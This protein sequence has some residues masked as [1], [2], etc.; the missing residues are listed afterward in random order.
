M[1]LLCILGAMNALSRSG[2]RAARA[3]L[4]ALLDEIEARGFTAETVGAAA[5]AISL[6]RGLEDP[7]LLARAL[8][9]G[10]EANRS[11][12]N[13]RLAVICGEEA[14]GLYTKRGDRL[15]EYKAR[16]LVGVALWHG[17]HLTEAFVAFEE[18]AALAKI[19]GDVERHVRSLNMIGVVLGQL[20][21]YPAAATALDQALA[22]CAAGRYEFDRVLVVNNKAQML[23]N[24]AREST[25]PAESVRHAEAALSLLSEGMAEKV[26][27]AWPAGGLLARDTLGQA[28]GLTGAPDQ[29]LAMFE[30]N[31]RLAQLKSDETAMALAGMGIA[32]ALLDLGRPDR[33]LSYCDALRGSEG[34]RLWPALLPRIENA[35]AK[36]LHALGRDAEAYAAFGRYHDRMMQNNI[37]VAFQYTKYMEL[38]VQLESSRAETATY[39]K[40]A[41]ELTL[42]KQAAEEASR[43]KSEFLANMSHELR[44]PL[45]SI[46]GFADL[47][48]SEIFGSILPKY[49]E[50]LQDIFASGQRL[51]SL[52]D[53]LLDLAQAESG[54][55]ELAEE[56]VPINVLLDDATTRLADAAASKDVT[57]QWSLRAGA[58][59]R[60]DR[61]RLA[62]CILN[63]LSNAID[64]VPSGGIVELATR[65][66]AGGLAVA[67]SALGVGLRPEDVPKAFERY[68]Q[69]GDAKAVSSTG[70]GLPLAKRLIELHGGTAAL[71]SGAEFGTTV[72]L[73][74]PAERLPARS[75]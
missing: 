41:H 42:A 18:A 14:A 22:L 13:W 3:R 2:T 20:R 35:A 56:F 29:A 67:I 55:L 47:I 73:R 45:N 6:A 75:A 69:G 43:A 65:F 60:G 4:P 31:E 37:R 49:R 25:D 63:V 5:E 54:A 72:T 70:F 11:A 51:L 17:A 16:Y 15:G 34:A 44:T 19:L 36:A 26:E 32:E 64:L 52:I 46:I 59:V 21:D 68:G 58:V 7:A 53:Q 48:R 57:F 12:G 40:L 71:D 62:Q 38:V 50:Y 8:M 28:V 23:V 27:Q 33:A 30:E 39:R 74:F 1:A 24:R 66:D 10:L 61:M 9:S